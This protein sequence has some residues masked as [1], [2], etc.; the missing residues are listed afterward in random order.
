M[1]KKLVLIVIL[2]A[3]FSFGVSAARAA[4]VPVP[5]YVDTGYT[6]TEDGTQAHP[7]NTLQ[8]GIAFAQ[9]QP[10][11]GWVYVKQ[12]DGSWKLDRYVSPVVSGA[13]GIPLAQ[14]TLYALLGA[15]TLV[16]LLA[17]WLLQRRA[18]HLRT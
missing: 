3:M 13:T 11:G 15:L 10:G 2:A 9:A 12:A 8:E 4:G 17:G 16:L 7:Y 1:I 18:R 6:G 5:I 14:A